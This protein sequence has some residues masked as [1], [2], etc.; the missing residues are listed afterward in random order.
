MYRG[1]VSGSNGRIRRLATASFIRR[2][3]EPDEDSGSA[4]RC[5]SEAFGLGGVVVLDGVLQKSIQSLD[6]LNLSAI[7]RRAAA[8]R[9][10][11]LWHRHWL[12]LVPDYFHFQSFGFDLDSSRCCTSSGKAL[13]KS[14][15]VASSTSSTATTKLSTG[16]FAPL[17]GRMNAII[18]SGGVSS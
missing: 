8:D 5:R 2:D 3:T 14:R 6:L 10:V 17:F 18:F 9:I 11:S 16:L 15:P 7:A 13:K 4:K 1:A 12:F